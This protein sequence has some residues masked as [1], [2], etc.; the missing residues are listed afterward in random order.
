LAGDVSV[1]DKVKTTLTARETEEENQLKIHE[2]SKN[3]F[4]FPLQLYKRSSI[5]FPGFLF[6]ENVL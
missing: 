5:F 4:H 1:T 2:K 3:I 6:T